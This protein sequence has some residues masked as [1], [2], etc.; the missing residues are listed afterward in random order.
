MTVES[1][2]AIVRMVEEGFGNGLVP[3]GI[4]TTMGAPKKAIQ[5]LLPS[6]KRPIKIISRKSI[7]LLPSIQEFTKTLRE[8]SKEMT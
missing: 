7:A 5:I 4:A 6:I 3:F 1:F 2:A 8:T